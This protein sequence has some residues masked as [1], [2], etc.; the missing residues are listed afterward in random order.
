MAIMTIRAMFAMLGHFGHL[1][2]AS[3]SQI[4][5]RTGDCVQATTMLEYFYKDEGE[6]ENSF[7]IPPGKFGSLL[8][9]GAVDPSDVEW[10]HHR[11]RDPIVRGATFSHQF[12]RVPGD[13]GQILGMQQTDHNQDKCFTVVDHRDGYEPEI[14]MEPCMRS[15]QTETDQKKRWEQQFTFSNPGCGARPIRWTQDP[16]KCVDAVHPTKVLLTDCSG[17][18]SQKFLFRCEDPPRDTSPPSPVTDSPLHPIQAD[19]LGGQQFDHTTNSWSA[20]PNPGEPQCYILAMGR[21]DMCLW[22]DKAVD[23]STSLELRPC[24]FDAVSGSPG[25]GA[26]RRFQQ[27]TAADPTLT[28]Q[29]LQRVETRQ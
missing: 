2:L 16:S 7:L 29:R 19:C 4:P 13:Q 22:W 28:P 21:K 9:F 18:D 8:N 17:V 3:Q 23:T 14:M 5:L 6:Y 20:C 26:S 11:T 15:P 1:A 27:G 25:D 24:N 12:V 10:L